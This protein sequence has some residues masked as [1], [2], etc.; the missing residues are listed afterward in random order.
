MQSDD[1]LPSQRVRARVE[2]P[3][4]THDG[5]A[6]AS[7]ALRPED[8]PSGVTRRT[9]DDTGDAPDGLQHS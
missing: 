1:R 7:S 8:F 5:P 6:F 4:S 3:P 9:H 2:H